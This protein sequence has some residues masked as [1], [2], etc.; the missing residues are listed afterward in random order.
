MAQGKRIVDTSAQQVHDYFASKGWSSNAAWGIAGNVEQESGFASN[1]Y[2]KT[3][4]EE[5]YGLFQ[6]NSKGNPEAYRQFQQKYQKPLTQATAMEQMEFVDW[7]L[8]NSESGAGRAISKAQTPY[9]A[10][11]TF[12]RMFERPAIV[13]A[14]RGHNAERFAGGA[15]GGAEKPAELSVFGRARKMGCEVRNTIP[16]LDKKDCE[17][18]VVDAGYGNGEIIASPDGA[19]NSGIAV[20]VIVGITGLALLVVGFNKLKV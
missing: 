1:A 6:F 12:G 14:S 4:K 10:G 15:K 9:D 2:N 20:R 17:Q 16:F 11:M 18:D 19:D 8:R 7:Q 5:S 13:E 3:A